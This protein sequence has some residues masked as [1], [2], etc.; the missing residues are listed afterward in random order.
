MGL[1]DLWQPSKL[2]RRTQV[3]VNPAGS[4]SLTDVSSASAAPESFLL[5]HELSS[6]A[7]WLYWVLDHKISEGHRIVKV[8][9]NKEMAEMK[10]TG[11]GLI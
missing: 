11:G 8:L 7:N 6:H 1:G 3:Q 5:I 9:S 2:H 10:L 4:S